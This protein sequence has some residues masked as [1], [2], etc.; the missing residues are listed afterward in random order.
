MQFSTYFSYG[1]PDEWEFIYNHLY[2]NHNKNR[3][4][5]QNQELANFL[6]NKGLNTS[7]LDSLFSDEGE[8][9]MEIYREAKS[10]QDEFRDAFRDL[11][12]EEI[13]IFSVFEYSFLRELTTLVKIK[14]LLDSEHDDIV[15]IFT[16]FYFIYF[17]ILATADKIGYT[18]KKQIAFINNNKIEYIEHDDESLISTVNN[19]FKRIR[20]QKFLKSSTIGKSFGS[21]SL[22]LIQFYAKAVSLVLKFIQYKLKSSIQMNGIEDILMQVDNKIIRTYGQTKSDCLLCITAVRDDLYLKP[23]KPVLEEFKNESKK[24]FIFTSD[25]STS[26]ALSKQGVPFVNLFEETNILIEIIKKSDKGKE[27]QAKLN[28]CIKKNT[29]VIG[30]EELFSYFFSQSLR[31]IALIIILEHIVKQSQ[32][33][34]VI[35]AADGEM[36]ESILSQVSRKYKIQ[37]FS[38]LP[39]AVVQRPIFSDWFHV[40]KI[41]VPGT[42]GSD[43]LNKLGYSQDRIVITGNPKYDYIKNVDFNKTRVLLSDQIGTD[44]KKKLIVVIMSRWHDNDETWMSNLIKF[45]N[46]NN[47]DIIIKIHPLYKREDNSMSEN[48][49]NAIK[50]NCSNLYFNIGYDYDLT[51][52]LVASD[53]VITEYSDAGVEAI[54]LGKIL[55]TVNFVNEDFDRYINYHK[56]DASIYISRYND[57]EQSIHDILIGKKSNNLDYGRERIIEMY[58]NQNDGKATKRIF[59]MLITN[60]YST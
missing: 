30:I 36:L 16:S 8:I 28:E 29:A 23:W 48:K 54:L 32:P 51:N 53:I 44:P 42:K 20:A 47:L 3:I 6:T 10:I 33:K 15:V 40:D 21:K 52:L 27:I 37:S 19:K 56:Y 22:S 60:N 26:L 59:R 17:A 14:K 43:L 25:L 13:D 57:L 50:K 1:N 31:S 4:I 38:I 49:I 9:G 46:K 39:A 24:F 11:L 12:F 34:S 45:C 18:C 7:T 58:N 41:F 35:A 55:I 5:V 2:K